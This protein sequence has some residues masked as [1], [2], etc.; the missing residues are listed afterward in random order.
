MNLLQKTTEKLHAQFKDIVLPLDDFRD[1]RNF[2]VEP[3][4]IVPVC[5]FLHDDPDLAVTF[6]ITLTAIDYWPDEPRFRVAYQLYSPENKFFIGLR[7]DLPGDNPQV[8]TVESVYPN[9]NWHEREV[10]DLFGITFTGHSDLRRIIMPYDWEGHPLRKDYPL[11]YE[12][13]QF[14]F[15]FDEIDKRKKYAKD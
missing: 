4:A 7:V 1:E 6:L 14:S 2:R 5:Q 13:V 12:E 9:A 15:N 11:G 3:E 8:S 10:Y